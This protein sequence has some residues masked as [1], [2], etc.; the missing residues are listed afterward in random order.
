M[1][2]S[3]E[4]NL[5][6]VHIPKNAGKSVTTALNIF[7]LSKSKKNRKRVQR[8]FIGNIGRYFSQHANQSS[9]IS[10]PKMGM[11]DYPLYMGHCTLQEMISLRLSSI[12]FFKNAIKFSVVR[13]PFSRTHSLFNHWCKEKYSNKNEASIIF[14]KFI[15]DIENV[16]NHGR[17]DDNTPLGKCRHNMISHF[18]LQT[19]YLKTNIPDISVDYILQYEKLSDALK[20]FIQSMSLPVNNFLWEAYPDSLA[21]ESYWYEILNSCE[22]IDKINKLYSRDFSELGYQ[23]K[24]FSTENLKS[25]NPAGFEEV[26]PGFFQRINMTDF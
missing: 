24:E 4:K 7:D 22:N 12:D 21:K 11:Y 14:S 8:N 19:E 13:N 10:S 16:R 15:N 26:S 17:I 1:A 25:C 5:V 9:L 2:I 23:C 3:E 18:N 6:F 20:T